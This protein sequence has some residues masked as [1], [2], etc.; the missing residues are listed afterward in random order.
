[1]AG[2]DLRSL[3]DAFYERLVLRDFLGKVV[4]GLIL[5][6]TVCA[7]VAWV[8]LTSVEFSNLVKI[9]IK[10]SFLGWLVIFGAAWLIAF[11]IQA[12]GQS[13]PWWNCQEHLIEHYPRNVFPCDQSYLDSIES[14]RRK[15]NRKTEYGTS[16]LW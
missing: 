13:F 9:L 5:L 12:F 16:A 10:L 7:S 8:N 6:F 4:P 1:M 14:F 3:F 15:P 11:A 2:D